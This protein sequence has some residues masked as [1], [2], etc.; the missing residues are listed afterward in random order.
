MATRQWAFLSGAI[1]TATTPVYGVR[2]TPSST[3]YP[4][5]RSG[6]C[7]FYDPNRRSFYLFAGY[8]SISGTGMY[9]REI[10]YFKEIQT[11]P[12]WI[13]TTPFMNPN[14][15]LHESK[16]RPSC[17]LA[18]NGNDMWQYNLTDGRWTWIT[19][20][21]GSPYSDLYAW[22]PAI[23]V[24]A[25]Q[26]APFARRNPSCY[27][28]SSTSTFFVSGGYATVANLL[29]TPTGDIWKLNMATLNWTFIGGTI[30]RY[31]GIVFGWVL[32]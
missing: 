11:S 6:G 22:F 2:G 30:S 8:L 29:D 25:Q 26:P 19:G 32:V 17:Y 5:G 24:E 3:N 13:Q 7:T 23:G 12:S 1:D 27:Y 9:F 14:H 16:P 28:N 20:S 31:V 15:A 10:D 18:R 4:G 21:N